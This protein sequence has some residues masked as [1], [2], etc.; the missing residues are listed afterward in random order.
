MAH[1]W[2]VA[3]LLDRGLPYQEISARDGRIDDDGD[4]G[5]A[6]AAPRRGRL[7]AG[8]RA[9]E[10]TL[11]RPAE[12]RRSGEGPAPG[13]RR[14][15]ARRR[16]ARARGAGRAALAFPCRNA[17][18]EVLLVRAADIPEYV[19]D[20]VVDCGITGADLVAERG[21]RVTELLR[22]GLRRLHARGGRPRGV[23]GDRPRRPRESPRR[24]RLP[25]SRVPAASRAGDRGRARGRHRLGRGRTAARPRRGHRR[26]R[27][28][29]EHASHQRP[30]LPRRALLV[31][32]R[33][34]RRR[35]ARRGLAPSRADPAQRRTGAGGPLPHAERPRDRPRGHLRD[36]PRFGRPERDPAR[37]GRHGRRPCA[38]P[39]RGRLGASPPRSRPPAPPRSSSS[40][41]SGWWNDRRRAHRRG[42]AERGDEAVC[43]WSRRFDGVEPR[44]AE[45]AGEIP[46]D[47]VRALA[48]AVRRWH[49]LQRPA[50][51]R[52]E[53]APG[54]VLERRWVPL[55]SV[56]IYVPRRLIST[57]VM[58]A[59]PAQIA[60]RRADRR[61]HA[62]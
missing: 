29:R 50:D 11:P 18:V 41:W 49:D 6:L 36:R 8:A 30:A 7:P 45:P 17:P 54:V 12:D 10:S 31:R 43:E 61:R 48:D 23:A 59:V 57:L 13:A 32:G 28:E 22:L 21:A 56:G 58:C 53:V 35:G 44:L 2:E 60:G 25:D 42:R 40:P 3:K 47:A 38:R 14:R 9:A 26:S 24:D 55:R 27:L 39:G 5:R 34:G 33:A 46:E 1:R 19:Q 15:A 4:A 20:G 62:A 37:A 52:A 16:G 51:V